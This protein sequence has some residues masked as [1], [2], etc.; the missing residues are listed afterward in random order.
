MINGSTLFRAGVLDYSNDLIPNNQV[1]IFNKSKND[2]I[3]TGKLLVG[4]NFLKNT[5]TGRIAEI[6]EKKKKLKNQ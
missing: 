3:G 1:I 6:I 4:R 5:S 2:I